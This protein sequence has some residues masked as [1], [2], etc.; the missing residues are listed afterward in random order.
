[1]KKKKILIIGGTGFIGYHLAKK[2]ISK[3][4]IVT[5][6][7]T[8]KPKKIRKLKKIEYLFCDISKKKFLM[9]VVKNEYDYVVNL[10]GHVDHR[11]KLK[12]YQSHFLGLK[13]LVDIFV[14][15]KIKSFIQIG[16][17]GEYG[18]LK[19]PHSENQ[20][21]KPNSI[22]YKS[23]LRASKLVSQM[24][25]KNKFPGIVLRLYQVYG[26]NQDLNRVIPIVVKNC[27]DDKKFDCSDGKQ[28]RDFTY[29]EDVVDAILLS[30]NKK[31]AHGKIFNIGSSKIIKI[32]DLIHKINTIIGFGK[33]FYGKIKLRDDENIIF[34][35]S[36]KK[37]NKILK[38]KPK[39]SFNT[40][41][42]KTINEIK[43]R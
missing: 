40:G 7:S 24:Y 32:R 6:L 21:G 12:T 20:R 29:V 17:G 30:L 15:K 2:C 27:L 11:N 22:Y 19:S 31:K 25:K 28:F 38:W 23:K 26:P 34:Y 16:S 14:K 41:L 18:K 9:K 42:K 8:R 1:M 43:K 37:A 10:G 35:P 5:S 36:I 13:N 4:F 39:I 3:N 33:P